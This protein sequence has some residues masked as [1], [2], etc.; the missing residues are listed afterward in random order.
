MGLKECGRF[1]TYEIPKGQCQ[2]VYNCGNICYNGLLE[3]KN[4]FEVSVDGEA[5]PYTA[6]G[7]VL[8]ARGCWLQIVSVDVKK[9]VLKR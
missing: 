9:L 7:D 8:Q 1:R 2:T 3:D 5:M 6:K 4:W